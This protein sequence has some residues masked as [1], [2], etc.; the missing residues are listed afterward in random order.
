MWFGEGMKDLVIDESSCPRVLFHWDSWLQCM[1]VT[2]VVYWVPGVFSQVALV[3]LRA[4]ARE[5]C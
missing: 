1:I 3:M 5:V 2:Q 4:R